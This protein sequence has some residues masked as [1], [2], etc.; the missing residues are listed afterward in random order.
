M[1]TISNQKPTSIRFLKSLSLLI[2]GDKLKT[3]IYLNCIHKVRKLLRRAI[4]DFYRIEHIYDVIGDF[5]KNYKGDFSVLEFGV[6]DGYSFTKMLFATRYLH[7]EGRVTV[8]GFDSFEGLPKTDD[9]KDKDLVA[10]DGWVEGQ[11]KT[12]YEKLQQ[13]CGAKYQNFV[14]HK[15]YFDKT[16][17]PEFLASLKTKPPILVWI[18]C[19]YYTSAKIVFERLKDYLPN[20][21]VV[22]FDEP[23]LNFGS[24]YTGESRLI[25]EINTG[26]YGDGIE[27]VLDGALSLNSRRVYRYINIHTSSV[28]ERIEK[29]HNA[30]YLRSRS[31]DS[32]FP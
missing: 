14:L 27:M 23:E 28:Y 11:F 2:P 25:H 4:F 7:C 21:C 16:L 9:Q 13:Y 22:Y 15:G 8:H 31:N 32:P 5:V 12:D 18:D 17:T 20:G 1:S 3:F 30:S 6:A 19:D 24:R 29:T 26:V 10:D